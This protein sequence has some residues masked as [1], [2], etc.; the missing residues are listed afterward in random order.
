MG[1]DSSAARP[2]ELLES[3]PPFFFADNV[4]DD[5]Q[6]HS[7]KSKG[8]VVLKTLVS[9]YSSLQFS[10]NRCSSFSS[11]ST[12]PLSTRWNC[13]RSLAALSRS[14]CKQPSW[15]RWSLQSIRMSSSTAFE[16]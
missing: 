8:A 4:L 12:V 9:H 13:S 3:V 16:N 11:L 2:V 15:S 14:H 10:N 5:A 6:Q 7:G 1:F